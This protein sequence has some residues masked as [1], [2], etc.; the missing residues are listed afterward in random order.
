MAHRKR[1]LGVLLAF[2]KHLDWEVAFFAYQE[3]P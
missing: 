1:Y 3:A 2:A